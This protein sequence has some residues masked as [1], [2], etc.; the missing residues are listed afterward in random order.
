MKGI[1]AWLWNKEHEREWGVLK[2]Q[3]GYWVASVSPADVP[4]LSEYANRQRTHHA[5]ATII[6][7][8]EPE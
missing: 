3:D 4:L 7:E 8:C 6:K 2:W 5:K 1:T